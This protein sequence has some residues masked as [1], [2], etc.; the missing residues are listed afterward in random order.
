MY[1]QKEKYGLSF[2][3]LHSPPETDTPPA[4]DTP[5][6]SSDTPKP[7]PT[8]LGAFSLKEET[9]EIPSGALFFKRN[10]VSPLSSATPTPN[11]AAQARMASAAAL[12]AQASPPSVT[13]P[14]HTERLGGKLLQGKS[15]GGVATGGGKRTTPTEHMRSPVGVATGKRTTPTGHM[16]LP[17]TKKIRSKYR[18]GISCN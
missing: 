3:T 15:P 1:F 12:R 18:F 14:T 10:A 16:N 11:A 5:I 17:E 8:K 9:K 2:V 7:V 6:S 13:S 4:K